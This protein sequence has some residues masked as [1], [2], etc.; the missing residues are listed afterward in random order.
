MF[1]CV[2][3]DFICFIFFCS[4]YLFCFIYL[5]YLFISFVMSLLRC[6]NTMGVGHFLCVPMMWGNRRNLHVNFRSSKTCKLM[7]AT[8][9]ASVLSF[10]GTAAGVTIPSL[11]YN[12]GT[13]S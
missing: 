2:C 1:L 11:S 8:Y 6:C 5:F 9:F 13:H 10:S 3:Y 7:N 4:T 12:K